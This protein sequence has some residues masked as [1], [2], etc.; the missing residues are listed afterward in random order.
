MDDRDALG[1]R[2]HEEEKLQKARK[3]HV[4]KLIQELTK[5]S[6][7]EEEKT[8]K[9]Y[10]ESDDPKKRDCK[11]LKVKCQMMKWIR[12]CENDEMREMC[13]ATCGLC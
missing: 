4:Q 8:R 11:D 3:E 12:G 13:K 7:E 1:T 6:I 5:L 9:R 10:Q 2:S